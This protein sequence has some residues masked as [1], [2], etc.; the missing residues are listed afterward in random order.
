MIRITGLQ[1]TMYIYTLLV[2]L[3]WSTPWRESTYFQFFLLVI[4]SWICSE[5]LNVQS[6][7]QDTLIGFIPSD[8]IYAG[9]FSP[10]SPFLVKPQNIQFWSLFYS[11]H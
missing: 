4:G 7:L 2:H 6:T 10:N 9:G 3:G 5:G 11:T 8:G 1:K